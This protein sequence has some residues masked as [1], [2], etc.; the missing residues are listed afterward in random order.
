ML[1]ALREISVHASIAREYILAAS[2]SVLQARDLNE[3]SW[4]FGA[5][6]DALPIC[7]AEG[8]AVIPRT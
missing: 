7:R 4:S 5:N 3:R 2:K 8:I 6:R 1:F